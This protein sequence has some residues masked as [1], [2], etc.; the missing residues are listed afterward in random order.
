LEALF[1]A[2]S[3]L[4]VTGM[5]IV[6]VSTA[7]TRLGQFLLLLLVQAGGVGY[8]FLLALTLLLVARRLGLRDRLTL[9]GSLGLDKPEGIRRLFWHVLVGILVIEGLG[10][11]LLY[12][13]WRLSG[14]V[15]PN[16][17][18]FYAVFYAVTA[19]CNAS[20][21]L[22]TGLDEYGSLTPG[23]NLSLLILGVLVVLGG[24]GIP[25]L[26]DLFTWQRPR[27]FTLHTRLTL[28]TVIALQV[29]GWAGLLIAEAPS[30]GVV[31]AEPLDRQLV[32]TWFQSVSARTAGFSA[33]ADLAQLAPESQFLLIGLMFVGTAPASMGGG[34][35]TTALA[36]LVVALWSYGRGHPQVQ[37]AQRTLSA[38][39]I[40]RAAM[41]LTISSGLVALATWL[42]LW[43]HD[44][45]LNT[46][47]FE[48]VSAFATA[49][50]SLGITDDLNTFG[51]LTIIF[52]MFWGRLGA[53]TLVVVFAQLTS[54][55]EQPVRYPEERVVL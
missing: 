7:L 24:L 51:L 13:H 16:N 21:D 55:G 22:F 27:R 41:I 53:I 42:I 11:L 33:F 46:V 39:T 4:T 48:V 49:G 36:V 52:M 28:W 44:L 25:V 54:S 45:A 20:F 3:A 30:G 15:S 17:T 5:S 26:S 23:D 47:L 6:Q 9:T 10:A 50:L 34:I 18:L 31:H 8:M 2:T 40:R 43:T 19:F 38:N 1:T 14:I 37:V 32:L 35:T 12:F 29:I